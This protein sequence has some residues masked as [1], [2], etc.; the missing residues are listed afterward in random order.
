MYAWPS[1][2]VNRTLTID[3]EQNRAYIVEDSKQVT[4]FSKAV[5]VKEMS[6]TCENV[7]IHIKVNLFYIVNKCTQKQYYE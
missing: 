2:D 1:L 4:E 5:K 3:E 7:T 6:T